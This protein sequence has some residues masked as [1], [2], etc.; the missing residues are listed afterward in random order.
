ME[1]QQA[2]TV[3][4][5]KQYIRTTKLRIICAMFGGQLKH[6]AAGIRKVTLGPQSIHGTCCFYQFSI[7][8]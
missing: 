4:L 6:F 5:S 2:Q 1:K 8:N 3:D 7:Q